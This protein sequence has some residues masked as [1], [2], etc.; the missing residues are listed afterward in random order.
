MQKACAAAGLRMVQIR[1]PW[2]SRAW[3][4]ATRGFFQFKGHIP[5]LVA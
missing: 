3:P 1:R 4:H 5:G 2:D